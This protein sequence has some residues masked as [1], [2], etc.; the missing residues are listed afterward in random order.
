MNNALKKKNNNNKQ[1]LEKLVNPVI[2]KNT[3]E[4]P[5]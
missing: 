3:G 1:K 5:T 4:W 2:V